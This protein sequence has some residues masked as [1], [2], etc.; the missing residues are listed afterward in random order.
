LSQY[1]SKNQLLGFSNS[2]L[3]EVIND[4]KTGF[5]GDKQN[6]EFLYKKIDEFL[7]LSNSKKKRL[8]KNILNLNKKLKSINYLKH[9][10]NFYNQN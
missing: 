8:D 2:S 3:D 4:G 10:I 7:S 5:L 1:Y 6:S 9:L